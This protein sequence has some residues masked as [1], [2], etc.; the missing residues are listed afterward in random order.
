MHSH[1][2]LLHFFQPQHLSSAQRLLRVT[3]YVLLATEKFK[4]KLRETITVP[5]LNQAKTFWVKEAQTHLVKCIQI[6][7]WKKQ[8]SLFIDPEGV[9]RW[10]GRLTNADIQY[11]TRHSVLLPR[12]HPLTELLVLKAH[13]RVSHNDIKET[14]TEV[15]ARYWILK[16]RS[17]VKRVLHKCLVCKRFEGRPYSAPIPL[18]LPGF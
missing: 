6:H 12:D 9:W 1:E 15:H 16:G 10:G 5:L 18:P 3:A 11:M 13:A 8:L 14:L 2:L 4:K 17:L 7:D